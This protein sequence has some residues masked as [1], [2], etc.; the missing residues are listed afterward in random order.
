MNPASV[1]AL[2]GALERA[3]RDAHPPRFPELRRRV[4]EPLAALEAQPASGEPASPRLA[5]A[6]AAVGAFPFAAASKDSAVLL[7]LESSSYTAEVVD[8]GNGVGVTVLELYDTRPE[9]ADR[10][11]PRADST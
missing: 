3:F 6:A 7:A 4:A 10:A 11:R 2:L 8:A 1:V 9:P 5:E